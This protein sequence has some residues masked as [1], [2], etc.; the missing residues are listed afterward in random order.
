MKDMNEQ[1]RKLPFLS[2]TSSSPLWYFL[3]YWFYRDK[4]LQG[5][6]SYWKFLIDSC[7][8]EY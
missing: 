7:S 2:Y 1:I 8:N 4:P 3:S 6:E 5:F